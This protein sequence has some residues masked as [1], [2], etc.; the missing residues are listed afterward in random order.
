VSEG[1]PTK[2][3]PA[4]YRRRVLDTFLLWHDENIAT[5]SAAESPGNQTPQKSRP[6]THESCNGSA[7]E[8]GRG[9][10][11]SAKA[12]P[13][14]A[15]A[16]HSRGAKAHSAGVPSPH[17]RPGEHEREAR[18]PVRENRAAANTKPQEKRGSCSHPFASI[19][20]CSTIFADKKYR[21]AE[22][23]TRDLTDPNGARYQAAPRPDACTSIPYGSDRRPASTALDHSYDEKPCED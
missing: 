9:C 16:A 12:R 11:R 2:D 5:T 15:R 23:R 10:N 4:L 20:S 8:S 1:R 14:K 22:I 19:R 7:K 18:S 21:G 3:S 6:S 13:H 17:S